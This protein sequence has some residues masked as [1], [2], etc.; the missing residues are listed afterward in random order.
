MYMYMYIHDEK[1]NT[2]HTCNSHEKTDCGMDH[3]VLFP[4]VFRENG[5]QTF[6]FPKQEF[7]L[8]TVCVHVHCTC[9][10]LS[11]VKFHVNH[12]RSC[13]CTRLLLTVDVHYTCSS[14]SPPL[15]RSPLIKFAVVSPG[16][17]HL[18]IR[19]TTLT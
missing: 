10:T 14:L 3:S 12:V 7:L 2:T 19:R 13:T 4:F 1:G 8:P 16:D 6:H 18:S 11:G 9:I 5:T 15:S 17:P